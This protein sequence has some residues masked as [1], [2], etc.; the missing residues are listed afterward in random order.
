MTNLEKQLAESIAACKVK[1]EALKAG[2][3]NCVDDF[4]AAG[5]NHA[6]AIQPS[7]TA[8]N[9]YVAKVLEEIVVKNRFGD[10]RIDLATLTMTAEQLSK[11]SV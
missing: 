9:E 10:G 2:V 7:P 5:L 4:I 1:D 8:L 6:L 11:R 3:R